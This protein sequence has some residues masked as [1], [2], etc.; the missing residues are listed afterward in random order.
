M[1][2]KGDGHGL[3]VQKRRET[4]NQSGPKMSLT[5]SRKATGSPFFYLLGQAGT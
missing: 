1:R 3:H 2:S 4:R 5:E